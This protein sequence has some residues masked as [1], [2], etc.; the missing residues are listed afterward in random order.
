M[1]ALEQVSILSREARQTSEHVSTLA[2]Q[3]RDLADS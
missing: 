2:C 1:Q 3:A